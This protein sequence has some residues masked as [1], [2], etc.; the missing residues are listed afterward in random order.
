M[1]Q[2][3]PLREDQQSNPSFLY[4]GVTQNPFAYFP[5]NVCMA[6]YIKALRW[7]LNQVAQNKRLIT[8]NLRNEFVS[9]FV[10]L[11]APKVQARNQRGTPRG[12]KN[13]LRG[14]QIF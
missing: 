13:F 6:Q 5:C 11:E 10:C 14:A 1:N 12:E 9:F 3:S 2:P 7:D 8:E 4:L